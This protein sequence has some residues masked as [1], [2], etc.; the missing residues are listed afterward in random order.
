MCTRHT[1]NTRGK[2]KKTKLSNGLYG[3]GKTQYVYL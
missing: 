3:R 1:I 2:E